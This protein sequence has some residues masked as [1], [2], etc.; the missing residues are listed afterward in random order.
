MNPQPG[1]R[2]RISERLIWTAAAV[3]AALALAS[4]LAIGA[5]LYQAHRRPA[6]PAA[7]TGGDPPPGADAPGPP[8]DLERSGPVAFRNA[9]P[10][11][12][13]RVSVQGDPCWKAVLRIR[14]VAPD[15]AEHYRYEAPFKPHVA[16][17]WRDPHLERAAAAFADE[18]VANAGL[19]G[20]TAALPPWGD[21]QEYYAAHGNAIR[22]ERSA[23]EA[24][25]ADRRPILWHRTGRESWRS[26]IYDPQT[27]AARVILEGGP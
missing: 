18:A 7:G 26:V 27:R 11:D 2:R 17:D 20:S 9:E 14:V 5:V 19:V 21:A 6:P 13:L 10:G 8:C 23:Y 4:V 3:S 12:T 1:P 15:G 16:L 22:V 25:R 24:L